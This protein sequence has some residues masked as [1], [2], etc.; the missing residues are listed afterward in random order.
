MTK[1]LLQNTDPNSSFFSKVDLIADIDAVNPTQLMSSRK[2]FTEA[3]REYYITGEVIST[4]NRYRSFEVKL[5]S[6]A[7][8]STPMESVLNSKSKLLI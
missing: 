1:S 8:N 3:M 6:I 2:S 4:K 7:K 5:S